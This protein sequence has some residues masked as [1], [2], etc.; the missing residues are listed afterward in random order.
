MLKKVL[1]VEDEHDLIKLLKY[2]LE[3][4][5]FKVSY[6]TDGSLA[7]AEIRRE[8]PDLVILDLMLPGIDGLE[9]CRQL[10][11]QERFASLPV[12][13][14]T[15]RSEEAD[16]VVGLEIG[17]DDY[18]TKPFSM[19]ELI[20]R[21]R[22]LLRR[23]E[24]V[25]V[26]RSTIQRGDLRIDPSAH[27]VTVSGKDVELSA[28]EFRLLHHLASHP[29][30]VFSRDQLLDRVWGND[31]SVTQRSVDVYIRRVREKI[32]LRPQDPLYLQTV[33]GVGYRF[34]TEHQPAV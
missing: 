28:L 14:L 34:A 13:M 29:G 16:R 21:V 26:N 9:V 18:V 12:L 31:R 20:A 4:E 23:H 11:R 30:M 15:A 7:L 19:R 33:H 6:T 17:A 8:M 2:N 32:E 27:S 10:R 22:V 25:V 24:P 3:K 5:G 1:I